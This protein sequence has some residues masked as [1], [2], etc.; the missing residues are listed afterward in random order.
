M[1]QPTHPL[2]CMYFDH[3]GFLISSASCSC[4]LASQTDGRGGRVPL[5]TGRFHLRSGKALTAPATDA[6]V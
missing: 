2:T 1:A 5:R 4:E 3:W 6:I